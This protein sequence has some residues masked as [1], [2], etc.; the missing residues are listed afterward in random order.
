MSGDRQPRPGDRVRVTVVGTWRAERPAGAK[1]VSVAGGFLVAHEDDATLEVLE[2][3]DDP[4]KSLVG[5]VRQALDGSTVAKLSENVW[6]VFGWPV[7]AESRL[8]DLD[9]R[10]C[11]VI[12]SVPGTPAADKGVGLPMHTSQQPWETDDLELGDDGTDDYAR[13]VAEAQSDPHKPV[14]LVRAE[15]TQP[16]VFKSDGPEPP[17]DVRVL[18]DSKPDPEDSSFPYLIRNEGGWSWSPSPELIEPDVC[19][20]GPWRSRAPGARGDSL[21]EVVS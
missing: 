10:G 9:V 15:T 4:S 6:W 21:R 20:S 16:R 5:E 1:Y 11:K 8:F 14:V 13:A 3:A 18:I 19:P 7:E 17:A 12:G 2:P